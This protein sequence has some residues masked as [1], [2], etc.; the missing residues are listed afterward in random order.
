MTAMERIRA[1]I[2]DDEPLARE[3]IHARLSSEP[4]VDVIGEC[5][6]GRLRTGARD[7]ECRRALRKA[8]SRID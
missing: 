6:N 7:R 5:R 1:L 3:G 2:V 4:D 8:D